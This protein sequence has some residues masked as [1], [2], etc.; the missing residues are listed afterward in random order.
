MHDE[1]I[2]HINKNVESLEFEFGNRIQPA[3]VRS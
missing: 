3:L 1:F 2:Q